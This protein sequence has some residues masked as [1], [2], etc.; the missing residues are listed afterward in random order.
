MQFVVLIGGQILI[1]SIAIY[2]I[3]G[4]LGSVFDIGQAHGKFD[5]DFSFN[6]TGRITFWGAI[7][8]GACLNL[9]QMATDQ[10]SVQRYLSAKS[11]REAQ[12]SLWLKLGLLLPV[13]IIFYLTGLALFA[14]YQSSPSPL[15]TGAISKSDQILPYF[16]IHEL[17]RGMPGLLVAAIFAASM[18]TLSAGL[19]SLTSATIADFYQKLR[20]ASM[21]ASDAK[22]LTLSRYLTV[23]Y[24]AVVVAL[25]FQMHRLGTLLEASNKAIGLVGGPLLGL[26]LLGML[27]KR[28]N[29][30]GAVIGWLAGVAILI[31]VCFYSHISF[32]WYTLIGLMATLLVGWSASW[33]FPPPEAIKLKGLSLFHNSEPTRAGALPVENYR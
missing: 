31:P 24:G 21:P 26:F 8:G 9:V 16:V 17:P 5:I 1:L 2:K 23:A 28:T 33:L 15:A 13:L 11:L 27:F 22:L 4:G 14:F 7:I 20:R 30:P 18:S 32:L 6:L 29:T 3:P 12:R 19:N 10:V 25:A